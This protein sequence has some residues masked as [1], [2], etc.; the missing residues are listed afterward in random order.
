MNE[1][2]AQLVKQLG[3]QE[4]QAQGGAGLLFKLAKD[5]LGGDFSKVSAALPGVDALISK[6]PQAGGVAGMLGGLASKLGAGGVGNLAS[7]AGALGGLKL[8]M[9]TIG[10]FIPVILNFAQSQGGK[11]V[12]AL[13]SKVLHK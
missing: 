8:D 12:V 3:V 11:E 5:K 13:L 4:N 9:A 2:I 1:L 6:A 10:K 7:I